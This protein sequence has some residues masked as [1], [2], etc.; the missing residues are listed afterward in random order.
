[1]VPTV[2][3]TRRAPGASEW[4]GGA[5]SFT[6]TWRVGRALGV[7]R[8]ATPGAG[9][10]VAAVAHTPP[11][12][13]GAGALPSHGRRVRLHRAPRSPPVAGAGAQAGIR[14]SAPTGIRAQPRGARRPGPVPS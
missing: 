5:P 6:G 10:G 9:P 13:A 3:T 7:R 14:V 11:R 8:S 1:M 12:E 2:T 4:A